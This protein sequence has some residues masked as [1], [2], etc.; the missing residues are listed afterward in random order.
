MRLGGFDFEV[1]AHTWPVPDFDQSV[2]DDRVGQA[3]DDVVPPLRPGDRVLEG[4]EV[5]RQRG[6]QLNVRGQA[7]D[8]IEDSMRRHEDSV[9]VRVFRHPF[10]L[11]DAADIAWVWADHTH[12]LFL[13]ELH[14][15][16]PQVDLL[17][18]V[19]GG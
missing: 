4:D 12:G 18:C 16:L 7:E 1:H 10:Q 9:Q 6:R 19:G 13:Y 14:E 3:F 5:I 11:R 8:T 15:V 2:A 17:T